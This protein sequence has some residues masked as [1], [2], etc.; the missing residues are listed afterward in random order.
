[1]TTSIALIPWALVLTILSIVGV[2]F[3]CSCHSSI[4]HRPPRRYSPPGQKKELTSA[5]CGKPSKSKQPQLRPTP[6]SA[7]S[8]PVARVAPS[9]TGQAIIGKGVIFKG[10]ITGSESLFIEGR[11][12]GSINLPGY[13]VHVGRSAHVTA[14]I[15]AAAVTVMGK[16]LGDI[17]ASNRVDI[18]AESAVTGTVTAARVSIEDGAF[19]KGR[20]E[21]LRTV[22]ES[23]AAPKAIAN[24]VE[25]F[26]TVHA[27]RPEI[28]KMPLQ[29]VAQTA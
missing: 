9:A 5:L 16:V 27:K 29:P 15:K 26:K 28:G 19:F 20:I 7:F 6:A 22:V 8:Q 1:M 18:R 3:N 25:V 13:Q 11:V 14:N 23:V 24:P 17:D 12:E 10:D 21:V 4:G 2:S